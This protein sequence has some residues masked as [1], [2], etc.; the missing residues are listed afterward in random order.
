MLFVQILHKK[1]LLKILD[2]LNNTRQ[3][4]R[5]DANSGF[6]NV[7][8]IVKYECDNS[9]HS[10]G[11][12]IEFNLFSAWRVLSSEASVSTI[13]RFLIVCMMGSDIA[14]VVFLYFLSISIHMTLKQ[15]YQ[16]INN[17]I[18]SSTR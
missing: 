8:G 3:T 16:F 18:H 9:S 10:S 7:G 15:Q 4:S 11:S 2:C 14:D 1:N 12:N 17:I 6:D 13:E 5:T